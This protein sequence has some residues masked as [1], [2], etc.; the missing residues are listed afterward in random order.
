MKA[1]VVKLSVSGVRKTVDE[2]RWK[3]EGKKHRAY[4]SANHA[5][6]VI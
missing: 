5:E 1:T 4:E 3:A 2:R 6:G